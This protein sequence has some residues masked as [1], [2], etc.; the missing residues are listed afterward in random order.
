MQNVSKFASEKVVY[1]KNTD[2]GGE[3][4]A[5]LNKSRTGR[6]C[7]NTAERKLFCLHF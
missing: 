3:G 4:V 7:K 1:F 5:P 2:I 6:H